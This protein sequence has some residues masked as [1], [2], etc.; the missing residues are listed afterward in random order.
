MGVGEDVIVRTVP[1]GGTA[2]SRAV[3]RGDVGADWYALRPR[4]VEGWRM[5][6]DEV[7]RSF[8]GRAWL[9]RLAPA[10]SASNLAAERLARAAKD[11][12]V[13]TTG[14]QPGLFGGP[15]YT[16]S[17]A[18]SA[19]A[20]ADVLE[21][22]LGIPVAPV[23]WAATD[24]ADWLEAAVTYLA[25]NT[26]LERVEL[27]GPA[28]NGVALADVMLGDL[29]EAV[30]ALTRVCGSAAHNSILAAV[31]RAYAPHVTVGA[32]YVSLMRALLEPLGIAVLDAAHAATREAADGVLRKALRA[33]PEVQQALRGRSLAMEASG[34][35][36]QVLVL[37]G[38]SLV[39]QT[40][41]AGRKLRVSLHD[42][43][44]VAED[45]RVG[46][47]SANV[48]LRPVVERALLPTVCYLAGPGELAYFAQ[49]PPVAE[50]IGM[51]TPVVAPRWAGEVYESDVIRLC[52]RLGLSAL[53]LDDPGAAERTLARARLKEPLGDAIDRLRVTLETQTRLLRNTLSALNDDAPVPAAVVNGLERDLGHRL[54]RFERR[55]LAAVKRRETRMM[56]DLEVARAALRPLGRPPE[57]VLNL[58]PLLVRF[59][60]RLLERMRDVA[61][62][63]ARELVTG[64]TADPAIGS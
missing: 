64:R 48:L 60:S 53:D 34:Y 28:S 2:L 59:G 43:P 24:D 15:G 51:P 29:D 7:R 54:D 40:D 12:V 33:A 19:L 6:A 9:D 25:T 47:L 37:D 38:L 21:N 16:W 10:F 27:A 61:T 13:V 52:E 14:Q 8:D 1:L 36:P 55:M 30:G 56:G 23:F 18:M 11:G 26:G 46:T 31:R 45:A 58:L 39:F 44:V 32:A 63:H 4:D 20:T 57:R 3:Q 62:T 22:E 41:A 50:S 49:V 5:H 17:K 42:A 35:S